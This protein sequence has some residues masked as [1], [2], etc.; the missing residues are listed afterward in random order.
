MK[1][2]RPLYGPNLYFI[3][4]ILLFLLSS[5]A[6]DR[7]AGRKL[8][9][10]FKDSPVI[11]SHPV[12]F[13]ITDLNSGKVIYQKGA[14]QYFTP[15][16]NAKLFTF[17]AGL[18]ML[19]DSVPALRYVEKG[20]SLIFWGTGDPS[21]LQTQLKGTSVLKFLKTSD[22]KLFFSPGRYT[23]Q[24]YGQGWSW[25]D[26]NDYYQA[27][28]NELPLMDNLVAFSNKKGKI[29]AKPVSFHDWLV[30]DT[31]NNAGEYMI[32]RD[33]NTNIFKYPGK[34]MI[35]NE[36]AQQIPYKL[37]T[38]LTLK[39]LQDT[40]QKAVGTLTMKMPANA[41]TI[42]SV[43]AENVL[44]EMML[45]S[46][47]FIAEQLLLVYSNQFQQELN[48]IAAIEYVKTNYLQQL[49]DKPVW[50]DG[51]GLSR[52]NL[53]T[54]RD[55]VSIL[56]MI[57]RKVNNREKLFSM[58]PAGGKTGTLKNAY[59][60]TD[61]PFVYGKTGTLSGIYNQSG[62]LLSSKGRTLAFS[63]MNNN[64]VEPVAEVRKEIARVMTYIHEKL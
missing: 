51:S 33:F 60:K 27:E 5:C 46:D 9:R 56:Q 28:I 62:Y 32:K 23:G 2:N 53:F 3:V 10:I 7:K 36:Y 25:D 63:F 22:R 16:S 37:S 43:P 57:D 6:T 47:N 39:L 15:A 44:R 19:P 11:G 21:F 12:G 64:F 34:G 58:L 29:G 45:P 4:A 48:G 52:M 8:E 61:H 38:A 42:Y 50:V 31:L 30:A 40:L 17:Y 1:C 59:P 24:I 41:R 49:P 35:P 13:M 55:M 18:Q 14:D 20:D 26:Y 54:P